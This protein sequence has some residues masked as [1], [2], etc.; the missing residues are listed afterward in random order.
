MKI[1]IIGFLVCC[2]ALAS[3]E[4]RPTKKNCVVMR[5]RWH[6]IKCLELDIDKKHQGK[7]QRFQ[8][9]IFFSLTSTI[10]LSCIENFNVQFGNLFTFF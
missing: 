2:L 4:C 3:V 1:A 6:G 7:N 8:T 9:Q 10:Y 5:V